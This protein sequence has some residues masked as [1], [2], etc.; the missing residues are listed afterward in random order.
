MHLPLAKSLF[1]LCSSVVIYVYVGYP[2]LLAAVSRLFGRLP[3]PPASSGAVPTIS[4]IIAAR[5]EERVIRERIE[6]L[7][8]LDYPADRLEFLIA[9]DGSRDGTCEIVREYAHLGVRL[10]DFPVNRGKSAVLNDAVASATGEIL[11]L[12]DANTNLHPSAARLLA[13]WFADPRVGVVCGQLKLV[14]AVSGRNVDGTYW[15]YETFLKKCESRLD[16]L[17]GANGAIYAVRRRLFPRLPG[18]V[19]VDDL[20]IP[21]LIRMESGS[22]LVYD[23]DAI[24]VE[25]TAP[26]VRSEFSRRARI[27]AGGFQCLS[28]IWPILNPRQGWI[29]LAFVSHKL[30]RW[31]G[32]FFLAGA[33]VGSALVGGE[34]LYGA[35]TLAQL[36][37]YLTAAG[38]YVW[39]ELVSVSPLIAL[40]TMFAAM[41][42][43]LLAG[44]FRW[45]TGRQS[46]TWAR[47]TRAE[48]VSWPALTDPGDG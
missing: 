2:L 30:L 4:V 45:A 12:S 15:K 11:L 35:I 5:D 3:R 13:R 42:V 19:A 9:S 32:P 14:D 26:E 28:L 29:S 8:E 33:L 25:E 48:A 23:A 27:G 6:N 38:G 24:A 34:P 40:P 21:L 17:L 36:T 37:L 39:P 10:L 1:W 20:V 43:A 7:L 31:T 47:T 41:N 46:G 18:K 16:A 22:R 44:F